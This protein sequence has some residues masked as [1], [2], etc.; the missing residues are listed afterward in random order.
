MQTFLLCRQDASR[1]QHRH[2]IRGVQAKQCS[3]NGMQRR[4]G[5]WQKTSY[6]ICAGLRRKKGLNPD[7]CAR[8]Y[9]RKKGVKTALRTSLIQK[10][11]YIN[12]HNTETRNNHLSACSFGITNQVRITINILLDFRHQPINPALEWQ[13][14]MKS[15]KVPGR[16]PYTSCVLP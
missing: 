3:A 14:R 4:W 13:D 15:T 11:H 12:I 8:H 7:T 1:T 16:V 10:Q 9:P 5:H 2:V 6:I